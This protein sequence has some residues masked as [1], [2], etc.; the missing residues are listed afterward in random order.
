VQTPE[1]LFTFFHVLKSES[2]K[3]RRFAGGTEKL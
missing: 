1:V 3:V 2:V